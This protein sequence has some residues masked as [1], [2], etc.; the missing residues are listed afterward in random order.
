MIRQADYI[1]LLVHTTKS[2][3]FAP[4]QSRQNYMLFRITHSRQIL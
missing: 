3:L 1:L 2:S 4:E